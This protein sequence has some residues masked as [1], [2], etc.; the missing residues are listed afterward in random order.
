MAVAN[1]NVD[2]IDQ[3]DDFLE[4]ETDG[5]PQAVAGNNDNRGRINT[6]QIKIPP[7]WKADP[8]LWFLQL[9]AQF[10]SAG[11]RADLSK[12]NQIVGKLDSD[13]LSK[14]SDIVK[15]P[16]A[17][18][19]YLTLKNRLLHEFQESDKK[20]LRT[21]FNDLS[22]NE[23]K[24]SDLLR[25]MRDKSCNIVSDALL[26]ELWTNRL[27]QQIQAILSCSS[28]PLNQQVI[29]ADKIFET[30]DHTSIQAITSTSRKSDTDIATQ[31]CKL[32]EQI[33]ALQKDFNRSRS[34]N[35]PAK[36]YRSRS[37]SN[38][39]QRSHNN[40]HCYYHRKYKSKAKKCIPPCTFK[41]DSKN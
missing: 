21:L 23:D 22:L 33:A 27:P 37:R 8:E 39:N 32:E 36:Q 3:N 11:I 13:I 4:D 25:K 6:I 7:F 38:S 1:V 2:N 34:R 18:N 10:S 19:K 14:V 31:F 5:N 16:P 12:Y 41:E 26:Q 9:E 24:P 35:S 15:N 28:E 17:A 40:K 30:L 29:M 20:K